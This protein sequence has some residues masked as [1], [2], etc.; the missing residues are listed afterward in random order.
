MF[1]NGCEWLVERPSNNPEPD[2]AADMFVTA[3]CG[4]PVTMLVDGW[5]CLAGHEHVTYGSFRQQEMEAVEA[6]EEQYA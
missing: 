1:E 6:F 2:S 4:A 3:P 5:E